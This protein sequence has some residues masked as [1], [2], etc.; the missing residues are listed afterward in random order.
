MSNS[1]VYGKK[2]E[3]L[4]KKGNARLVDNAYDYKNNVS[5]QCFVS[6]KI[7]GKTFVAIYE[8]KPILILDKSIYVGFSILDLSKLLMYE[9]HY[10]QIQLKYGYGA[11]LLFTDTDSLVYEIER[12]NVYEDFYVNNNLFDF[13]DY[14]EDSKFFDSVNKK[15][16]GKMKDEVKRKKTSEFVG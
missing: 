11:N 4:R 16:I 5:K 8:I 9:F 6:Q 15:V 10:K 3:N 1:S 13:S 2:V 7:F 12:D 14:P